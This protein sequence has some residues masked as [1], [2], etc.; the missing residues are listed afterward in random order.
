MSGDS[1]RRA[2]QTGRTQTSWEVEGEKKNLRDV[3]DERDEEVECV[4]EEITRCLNEFK[5][6]QVW[7]PEKK[8]LGTQKNE[9]Q[10]ERIGRERETR[11]GGVG[12][13]K[14]SVLKARFTQNW[15]F[16]RFP[17]ALMSLQA[18]DIFLIHITVVDFYRVKEFHTSDTCC[19]Q[20]LKMSS[21]CWCV[22]IQE[23]AV[24]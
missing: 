9:R 8:T 22:V 13:T 6:K 5:E 20:V 17:L 19:G 10:S 2:R 12:K 18:G 21:Y 24:F 3:W 14:N 15:N 1:K 11:E 16:T 7:G 23:C 4:S